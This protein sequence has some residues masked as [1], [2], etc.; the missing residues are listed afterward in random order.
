V[1]C[2]RTILQLSTLFKNPGEE[3]LPD[4]EVTDP[5]H[6]LFGRRFSLVSR[7]HSPQGPGC[8]FVRYQQTL[9]L[10]I[11]LQA[12]TLASPR[13]AF[14]TRLTVASVQE[15]LELAE[16]CESSCPFVPSTCGND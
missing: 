6:P 1:Q 14:S 11:P 2:G 15:I 10:R 13:P 4:I 12:T 9:I 8:V 7:S 3:S 5:T 16:D